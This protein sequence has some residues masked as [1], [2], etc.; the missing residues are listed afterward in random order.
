[1]GATTFDADFMRK[2]E[3]LRL[4]AQKLFRGRYR[5]DHDTHR[6][7]TSLEFYD[8]RSYQPGD[9]FRYIDWNIYSRLGRLFVKLFTAEEDLTIHILLD[10]SRS[11][12]F[13]EPTKLDYAKQ[14]GAALGYIGI[15]NLD[16][17]RATSFGDKIE[18][19]FDPSRGRSSMLFHF[20]EQLKSDGNTAIDRVLSEYA[21]STPHP[22]LA[23]L[24]T[25][26]F[27]PDG[28]QNGLNALRYAGHDI[29]LIHILSEDEIAPSLGGSVILSDAETGD[30]LKVTI[31]RK[32]REAYDIRFSN[33]IDSIDQFCTKNQIEYAR[34]S[35]SVPFE[36]LVLKYLRQG[37]YLH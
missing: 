36:D 31:D 32:V 15:S 16:R 6:K 29:M 3:F 22:G 1:M 27:D 23:I 21:K 2:L 25:D 26:L 10:T 37:M 34:A 14:V 35:T 7:G 30:E 5:G 11:M 8:Y 19:S 4:V 28:Y 18:H 17:V 20:F 24:I 12:Q 9:D 33:Y 13:G